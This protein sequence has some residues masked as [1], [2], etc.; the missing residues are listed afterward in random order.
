MRRLLL[1]RHAKSDWSVGGQRDIDRVLAERGRRVAPLMGEYLARQALR[2]DQI[3][4]SNAKRTRQT[5]ELILPAFAEAPPVAYEPRIYEAPPKALLD[6]V[7]ET[8]PDVHTLLLIGHNPGMQGFAD[9]L[10]TEGDVHARQSLMEK[11]PTAAL[12]VIDIPI[13]RWGKLEPHTGRLDRFVTPRSL[14]GEEDD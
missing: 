8:R 11:F 3:L 13:D 6:V 5:C 1:L 9:L 4:V 10:V 12:A 7:R 14:D 2:P